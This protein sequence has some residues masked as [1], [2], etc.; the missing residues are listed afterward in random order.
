LL[1]AIYFATAGAPAAEWEAIERLL[2]T[3]ID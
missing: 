1:N 2:L 3:P